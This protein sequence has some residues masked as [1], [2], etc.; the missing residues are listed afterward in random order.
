MAAVAVGGLAAGALLMPNI[1]PKV[2]SV[3]AAATSPRAA[4][5][6]AALPNATGPS[7]NAV[8]PAATASTPAPSAPAAP[9]SSAPPTTAL[10]TAVSAAPVDAQQAGKSQAKPVS[11]RQFSSLDAVFE[12]ASTDE[13]AAW[14][15]LSSL[16]GVTLDPG[17]PCAVA[18]KQGLRCYLTKGGLGPIRQLSRPGIV[19][20]A[21]E[22]GRVAYAL[23]V[24]LAEDGATFRNH[25]VEQ[26]VPLTAL[27][28]WRGEFVT[29]WRPPPGYRDAELVRATGALAP[30]LGERLAMVDEESAPPIGADALA[31]RI[32]AFQLAQGLNPDGVA[33]PLTLM[34]LNRLSGIEEPRLQLNR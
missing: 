9:V 6:A 5:R 11:A 32:F 20:L 33:G 4:S 30:W 8:P 1:V 21:D 34:Q 16:W 19:K 10:V 26:T 13:S 7:A 25:D 14:R 18:A 27:A 15:A 22:Q 23:L 29:F 31:A 17:E 28:R 3:V 2:V 24:G 12:T